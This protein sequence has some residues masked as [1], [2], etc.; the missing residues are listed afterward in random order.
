MLTLQNKLFSLFSHALSQTLLRS[1]VMKVRELVKSTER[2]IVEH[3]Q[4]AEMKR[5]VK[6][7]L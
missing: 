4:D 3:Y 1:S 7:V 2:E 6:V 5:K